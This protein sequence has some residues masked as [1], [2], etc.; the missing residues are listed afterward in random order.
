MYRSLRICSL[1]ALASVFLTGCGGT[2][3]LEPMTAGQLVKKVHESIVRI[4]IVGIGTKNESQLAGDPSLCETAPSSGGT[5]FFVSNSGHILTNNHVVEDW[6]LCRTSWPNVPMEVILSN[7]EIVSATLVGRDP[8]TDLA[9]I[10]V[11]RKDLPAL[12]FADFTKIEI[13]QDVVAIGFPMSGQ[14]QGEPTVTKGIVSARER[15]IDELADLIQTDATINHGNSG[16]PLLNLVGE[17]VGVNTVKLTSTGKISRA[18]DGSTIFEVDVTEGMNFAVSSR[19]AER[20]SVDLIS[21][22]KVSRA[23]LGVTQGQAINESGALLSRLQEQPFSVGI[24]VSKVAPDTPAA[25]ILRRCDVVEAIGSFQIASIGDLTNALLWL[26]PGETVK[27]QYRRYPE[28]KCAE[29]PPDPSGYTVLSRWFSRG[30]ELPSMNPEPFRARRFQD[31][32]QIYRE[33]SQSLRRDRVLT[34]RR[35][36]GTVMTSEVTLR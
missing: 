22:N 4:R 35:D 9:V 11:D 8:A 10:K 34:A 18:E 5:G 19:I 16:G 15:A 14:L 3:P 36:E 13:G 6:A 27:L 23:V 1:A 7:N 33:F 32:D 31:L 24:L 29:L 30:P 21:M 25:Q 12:A 28:D 17:V 20:V 26:R 2:K